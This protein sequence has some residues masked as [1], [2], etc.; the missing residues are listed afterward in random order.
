MSLP[1]GTARL[2]LRRFVLDDAPA[3]LDLVSHPSVATAVP[4]IEPTEA[5][6]RRYLERQLSYTPFEEGRV[7][8]LA[9]VGRRA[10]GG[11][12]GLLTLVCRGRSA[13]IGW[14]LAPECRGQGYAAEAGRALLA[15]AFGPLGL[16]RVEAE[17]AVRN[18]ASWHLAERLGMARLA[19]LREATVEKG[20][21]VDSY[22]YAIRAEE[23]RAACASA[24]APSAGKEAYPWQSDDSTPA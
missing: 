12:V 24:A 10:G 17:A 6:V 5:G 3:L 7:F 15:Y 18:E 8:D 4:E 23:W 16:E 21:H 13:A 19:R 9:V 14:A 20:R 1:I 22:L 2:V 11:L